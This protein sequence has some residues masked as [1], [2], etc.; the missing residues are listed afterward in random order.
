MVQVTEVGVPVPTETV[1]EVKLCPALSPQEKAAHAGIQYQGIICASVLMKKALADYYVTN[2][3]DSWV[4]FTAVI[5]MTALVALARADTV[6]LWDPP[7]RTL[8][9]ANIVGRM[10]WTERAQPSS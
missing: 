7:V 10:P 1:P 5:E 4:P 3:I 9:V 8:I 6:L 2:L